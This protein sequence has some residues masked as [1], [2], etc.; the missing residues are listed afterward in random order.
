MSPFLLYHIFMYMKL[1][2]T[3]KSIICE[4]RKFPKLKFV[5]DINGEKVKL[6]STF[7][8]WFERH[9]DQDYDEMK[10]IYFNTGDKYRVGVPDAMII[11]VFKRNFNKIK[12]SFD[13]H[14]KNRIIF[15]KKRKDNND[16]VEFDF[17]EF[18]LQKDNNTYKIITSSFSSDGKFL[19]LGFP[20]K[21]KLIM[22]EKTTKP[23]YKLVRL[24]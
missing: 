17:I 24:Q 2:G 23:K 14:N 20:I 6:E 19:V 1:L 21:T 15:V 8:Q 16:E 10:K 3:I 5:A 18:L 7:H 12:Q 22:V 9:G 11:D 13:E 4:N